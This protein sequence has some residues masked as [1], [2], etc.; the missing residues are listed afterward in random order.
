VKLTY[1][2]FECGLD[3]FYTRFECS[4]D[5][6][7]TRFECSFDI[8]STRFECG[9]FSWRFTYKRADADSVLLYGE[10]QPEF[11]ESALFGW[12]VGWARRDKSI[13][14][15]ARCIQSS[16]LPS[17]GRF[18][19]EI[20]NEEGDFVESK[21]II[22]QPVVD[23]QVWSNFVQYD[24]KF[25]YSFALVQYDCKF[26]YSFALVQYDCKFSYSFALVKYDCKFP[27]SFALVQYDC[28]F[29]YSFAVVQYDCK[30]PYSFA[31]VQY[32]CKFPYSVV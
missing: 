29:P 15:A 20:R 31:L 24:C 10:N 14:V 7:Y 17:G 12:V 23:Q 8:F 19:W 5:I 4:C 32:D 11:G 30:F 22:A 18:S 9:Y 25:P 3:I 2:R 28:K 21:N 27:Y 13:F 1:T 16:V 6:F 26:S